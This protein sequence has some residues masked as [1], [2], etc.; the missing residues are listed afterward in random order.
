MSKRSLSLYE[1]LPEYIRQKDENQH[2]RRYLAAADTLL[3]RL[4]ATLQQYY[5]DN[6]PD[7]PL[8]AAEPA[9]QEWLLPYFA[10]LLDVRLVSPLVDGK[11]AEISNAAQRYADRS[12]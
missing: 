5:A 12:R 2:T 3:D 6:F 10:E 9:A 1:I 4:Y 11:R 7:L 8:D